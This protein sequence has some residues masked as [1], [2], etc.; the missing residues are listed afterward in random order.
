MVK[1][2]KNI[3][4]F[5]YR[6]CIFLNS[7]PLQIW[8]LKTSNKDMS[9]TIKACSLRFCQLKDYLVNMMVDKLWLRA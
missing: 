9:K 8:T 5:S 2:I 6:L 7:C 1:I 3:S 4:V